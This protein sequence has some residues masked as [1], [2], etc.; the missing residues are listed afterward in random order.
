MNG[1]D[2]HNNNNASCMESSVSH[3]NSISSA[4][5]ALLVAKSFPQSKE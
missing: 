5:T 1:S 4:W 2:S 3:K